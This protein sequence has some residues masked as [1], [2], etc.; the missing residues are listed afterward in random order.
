MIKH[1]VV[2]TGMGVVSPNAIGLE[3]F[4]KAI[5]KGKSG[6]TFHQKL[7]D[8]KFSCCIGGIPTICEELKSQYLTPLQL[9]G[10]DS[11]GILYGCI[12][13]IDAWKDAAV[14]YTHLTLPTK[15]IV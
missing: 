2:I 4:L 1:R 9:R 14:S 3:N 13:G 8:L 6:I 15:R 5:Q 11:A 12:A 7:Q 10:F